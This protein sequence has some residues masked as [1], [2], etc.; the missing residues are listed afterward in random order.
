MS[1]VIL[2][3]NIVHYE[4]LGRGRPLIF[5]H[6]WVGSWRYWM[7]T[8]QA[9]SISFRAYA[10]DLWGFGDSARHVEGYSLENQSRLLDEFL[11]KLGIGKIALIGHGLGALAALNFTARNSHIVDR[12]MLISLPLE[13]GLLSPRLSTSSPAELAEWLLTRAPGTDAARQEAPKTDPQAI[14]T[15][16]VGYQ[17]NPVNDAVSGGLNTF[18]TPTL[19]VHGQND[20]AVLL[21]ELEAYNARQ[22]HNHQIVFEQS[23]HFPM[24]EEYARF[25]RMLSDFL[26]LGSGESPNEL[27]I[28]EEWKRRVR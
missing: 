12:L 7:P 8:M 10:V 20:P 27:E 16:L 19:Y 15:S 22:E 23:G 3:D 26:A 13:A 28:K 11:E 9:A 25:H 1:V 5:L 21:A 14:Q 18:R 6:G 24:L 2:Q 4:V 17:N